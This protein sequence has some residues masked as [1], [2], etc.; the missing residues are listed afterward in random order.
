MSTNNAAQSLY[1]RLTHPPVYMVA[2][3]ILMYTSTVEEAATAAARMSDVGPAVNVVARLTPSN[4]FQDHPIPFWCLAALYSLVAYSLP[5]TPYELRSTFP[6]TYK[7]AAAHCFEVGRE[8]TRFLCLARI[9]FLVHKLLSPAS[10]LLAILSPQAIVLLDSTIITLPYFIAVGTHQLVIFAWHQYALTPTRPPRGI[11]DVE[12]AREAAVRATAAAFTCFCLYAVAATPH[13]SQGMRATSAMIGTM[14]QVCYYTKVGFQ[15][16]VVQGRWR[17]GRSV[18]WDMGSPQDPTAVE[19]CLRP[20]AQPLFCYPWRWPLVREALCSTSPR[21][22]SDSARPA[23]V[24]L[25]LMNQNVLRPCADVLIWQRYL[26]LI[27]AGVCIISFWAHQT[28]TDN[29]VVLQMCYYGAELASLWAPLFLCHA[30]FGDGHTQLWRQPRLPARNPTHDALSPHR[31]I[32][33]AISL[34][35]PPLQAAEVAWENASRRIFNHIF[36]EAV[37]PVPEAA[38]PRQQQPATNPTT[39]APQVTVSAL[40]RVMMD[41]HLQGQRQQEATSGRP[42]P[43]P[44]RAA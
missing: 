36:R 20:G 32:M 25:K 38:L 41:T 42:L 26:L 16:R 9:I 19:A 18:I 4:D 21:D 28:F 13:F 22:S 3:A 24:L 1:M 17:Q 8:G 33:L 35:P 11:S 10:V 43:A 44:A 27:Q 2:F 7:R 14:L 34:I 40:G 37:P 29:F 15:M 6:H 23:T 31:A 12:M 30:G 5:Q 39:N